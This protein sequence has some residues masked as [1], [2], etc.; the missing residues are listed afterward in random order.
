[1]YGP[2]ETTIWSTTVRAARLGDFVPL[3]QPIAN[4]RLAVRTPWGSE[5]PAR[6]PANC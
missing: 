5:C 1:M 3:G 2:T 6:C 4:T